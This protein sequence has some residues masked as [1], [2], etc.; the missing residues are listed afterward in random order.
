MNCNGYKKGSY[1]IDQSIGYNYNTG[2]EN[3][4]ATMWNH[5]YPKMNQ[6]NGYTSVANNN[7]VILYKKYRAGNSPKAT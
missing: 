2:N 3:D 5:S 7:I 1:A 6:S 4:F